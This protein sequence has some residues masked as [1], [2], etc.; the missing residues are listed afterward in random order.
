MT[1]LQLITTGFLAG[2]M[3]ACLTAWWLWRTA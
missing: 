3:S 1:A 2:W